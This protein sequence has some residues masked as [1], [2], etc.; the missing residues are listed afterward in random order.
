MA[1]RI[2]FRN[3]TLANWTAANPVLAA[4]E[5]GVETD[6]RFYKI[7]D[8]ITPWN[9]LPYAVLRSLDNIQVAEMDEQVTPAVP[10]PGKL[11]F[12]A[13]S[14]GGRMLLRQ[15]GPS[16]LS[17]PLQPSFFQNFITL[18]G[19]SSG[20]TLSAIGNT[21]TSVGTISH[22]NPSEAYGYMANIASAATANA[23]AGTGTASTLWLRGA[24]G[25]GGFFFATRV[26]FPDANYNETGAGTGTRVFVGMTSQTMAVVVSGN[27]PAGSHAGFH[28]LHLNASV[29]D[30]NWFFLTCNGVSTDRTD[31]GMPFLP[32]KIYDCYLFCAP[33]GN[34]ISWRI[35]N[36]T[37]GLSASGETTTHLPA[38]DALLRAGAQLATVNAVIR[39]LRL[40]RIYIESDR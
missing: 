13:K 33:S 16:G 19:P 17:T 21:V 7:G 26:A 10:A 28:R 27:F 23:T 3:D 40:Q 14:L 2:Q 30:A 35:D 29:Q 34:V 6:T 12:Y 9:A 32:G 31:T 39:N 8:G 38:T 25:G 1:Q 22:P 20:T 4:G 24:L 18:I 15:L 36:L 5:L 11:K 37:D